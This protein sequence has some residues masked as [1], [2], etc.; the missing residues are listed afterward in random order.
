MPRVQPE[1]FTPEQAQFPEVDAHEIRL[2]FA[3]D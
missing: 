1:G 2:I 3:T